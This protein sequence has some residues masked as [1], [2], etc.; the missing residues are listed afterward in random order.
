MVFLWVVVEDFG[1]F[2]KE[3]E[4]VTFMFVNNSRGCTLFLG[5]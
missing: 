4:G 2:W 3:L 5:V 1:K